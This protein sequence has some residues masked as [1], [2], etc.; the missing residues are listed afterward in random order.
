M[1]YMLFSIFLMFACKETSTGSNTL[2]GSSSHLSG[3]WESGCKMEA[4]GAGSRLRIKFSN[5]K[6]STQIRYSVAS[7]GNPCGGKLQKVES[8]KGVYKMG[9]RFEWSGIKRTGID[10]YYTNLGSHVVAT[11]HG[12]LLP[13]ERR[14]FYLDDGILRLSLP[15]INNQIGTVVYYG[16]ADELRRLD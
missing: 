12:N 11:S 15:G 5:G 10:I 3:T 2:G 9:S 4:M 8:Y 13:F 16:K 1:R 14:S 6:V 7:S